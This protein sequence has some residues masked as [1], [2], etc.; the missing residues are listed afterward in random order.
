MKVHDHLHM[1]RSQFF[2]M[3]CADFVENLGLNVVEPQDWDSAITTYG[4]IPILTTSQAV[5]RN[6]KFDEIQFTM[7]E[8]KV[9]H[10]RY[11]SF[12]A[13]KS[14]LDDGSWSRTVTCMGP[15]PRMG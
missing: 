6:N 12:G 9:R 11:R 13:I 3:I 15:G 10:L 4:R 8:S 5:E 1:M 2:L 7:E 14:D